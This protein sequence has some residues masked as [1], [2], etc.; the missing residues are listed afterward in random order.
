MTK[1]SPSR[2]IDRTPLGAM[3]T[4]SGFVSER[5][6]RFGPRESP[7]L[8]DVT[9]KERPGAR[10]CDVPRNFLPSPPTLWSRMVCGVSLS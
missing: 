3:M 6:E 9:D 2:N 1:R 7:A 5:T 10:T 8:L 4:E